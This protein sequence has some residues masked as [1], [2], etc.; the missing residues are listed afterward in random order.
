LTITE[1]IY[2]WAGDYENVLSVVGETDKT[3]YQKRID[4]L[5]KYIEVFTIDEN[6]PEGCSEF[7]YKNDYYNFLEQLEHGKSYILDLKKAIAE[8]YI[9]IRN[10]EKGQELIG[11]CIEE[12]PKHKKKLEKWANKYQIKI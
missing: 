7:E 2:N 1:C 8:S 12:Y 6:P 9:K 4:F 3:Y 11:E 10:K 5:S